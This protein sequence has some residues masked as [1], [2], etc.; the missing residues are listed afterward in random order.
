[1]WHYPEV[2]RELLHPIRADWVRVARTGPTS[3]VAEPGLPLRTTASAGSLPHGAWPVSGSGSLLRLSNLL[4]CE[5]WPTFRIRPTRRESAECAD[6][7]SLLGAEQ[8]CSRTR[9]AVSHWC[10]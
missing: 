9:F 5:G 3:G 4:K 2:G 10:V 6:G 8:P 7:H 1:M